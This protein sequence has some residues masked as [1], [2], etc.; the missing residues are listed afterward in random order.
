MSPV[1]RDTATGTKTNLAADHQPNQFIKELGLFLQSRR[2]E[3]TSPP[4][5]TDMDILEYK[6]GRW[7]TNVLL[8]HRTVHDK[9]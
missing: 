2:V 3:P 6:Q 8:G 4:E 5:P 9:V 7:D 1:K